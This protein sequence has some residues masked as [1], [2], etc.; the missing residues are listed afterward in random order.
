ML[1]IKLFIGTQ[2]V[3][4]IKFL[5]KAAKIDLIPIAYQ[6]NGIT[7]SYNYTDSGELYFINTYLHTI[8][9]SECPVFYDV[10]G[11]KGDYTLML[12]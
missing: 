4:V 10:G 3:K 6:L 2:V 11:N 7:K 8:V 1:K 5:A 12:K 9:K